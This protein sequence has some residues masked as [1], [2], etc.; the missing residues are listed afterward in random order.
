MSLTVGVLHYRE[1]YEKGGV[2]MRNIM[3]YAGI[4]LSIT[5]VLAPTIA[6]A[7]IIQ[8]T[9]PVGGTP[10]TGTSI[11][12]LLEQVANFL[13]IAG[14]IIAVI[15]IVYGGIRALTGGWDKAKEVLTKAAIGLAIIFGVGL[16]MQTIAR[17][18]QT[19]S[20]G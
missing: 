16:I 19:Q 8:P 9:S 15:V 2:V 4:A 18:V 5:V 10:V 13:L 11:T 14:V 1:V 3:K 12:G 7:A 20:I 17:L 6:L